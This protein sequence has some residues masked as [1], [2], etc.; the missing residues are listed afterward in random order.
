MY[1]YNEQVIINI[2]RRKYTIELL[3]T[4]SFIYRPFFALIQ[5]VR[6]REREVYK[7]PKLK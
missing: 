5:L 7:L 3:F 2:I 6:K 1:N 4:L